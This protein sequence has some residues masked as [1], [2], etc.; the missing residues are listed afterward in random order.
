M[1]KYIH[2]DLLKQYAEIAQ[3]SETPWNQF[4]IRNVAVGRWE[5]LDGPT[6]FSPTARYR[7]KPLFVKAGAYEFAVPEQK[8][9]DY[10]EPYYCVEM[11]ENG[12]EVSEEV[13]E[14]LHSE[15]VRLKSGLIQLRRIDAEEQARA[16]NAFLR[17][18]LTDE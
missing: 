7:R 13:W 5:S 2:A 9:L 3:H 1:T 8:E 15:F 10:G 4:Q 12:F 16:L 18:D 14:G 11:T 17:G 6:H